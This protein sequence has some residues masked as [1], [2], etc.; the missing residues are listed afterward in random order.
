MVLGEV[1]LIFGRVSG[2]CVRDDVRRA[3]CR[4][5]VLLELRTITAP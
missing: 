4:Q 5:A 1:E 2:W 3:I